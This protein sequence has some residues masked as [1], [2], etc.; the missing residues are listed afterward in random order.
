MST[1][2][3]VEAVKIGKRLAQSQVEQLRAAIE[4]LLNVAGYVNYEDEV[5]QMFEELET[6][7]NF[8]DVDNLSSVNFKLLQ[9]DYLLTWTTN[10][11]EDRETET[12]TLKSIENYVR[13]YANND[14]KGTCQFW[15]IKGTDFADIVWQY[16]TGKFLVEISKFR[17][18]EV[19][20]AFK[21]FFEKFPNGH[22]EIA[23]HGWGTSH[24]FVCRKVDKIN[25]VYEWFDKKETTVLPLH[26]AA[27]VFTLAEFNLGAK[28][29]ELSDKQ[30]VALS[31]IAQ[32]VSMPGLLD[33][34]LRRGKERTK[35]LD[36]AGIASKQRVTK[37]ED[38]VEY[39]VRCYAYTPDKEKPSTWKLPMCDKDTLQITVERLGNAAAAFS[40]GGFRG[41]PVK[42]PDAD[43]A[44]VKRRIRSEYRKLNVDLA[45]VPEGIKALI[46]ALKQLVLE[47]DMDELLKKL[48]ES[49]KAM[50]EDVRGTLTRLLDEMEK[51]DADQVGMVRQLA[52]LVAQVTEEELR[53]QLEAV[54]SAMQELLSADEEGSEEEVVAQ[55]EKI[56]KEEL[57][58]TK[59]L[60]FE[61][62]A[63][64]LKLNELSTLLETQNA[65]I[66][67]NSKAIVENGEAV[68]AIVA[69]VEAVQELV[70]HNKQ[71][72]VDIVELKETVKALNATTVELEKTDAVKVAE[73][74]ARFT[75]FWGGFRASKAAETVLDENEAKN[76]AQPEVPNIISSMVNSRL[77]GK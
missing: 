49:S 5:E 74:Q 51:A 75:P 30:R 16:V 22:P 50:H 77:G 48:R 1:N 62:I 66:A 35:I 72:T 52:E 7:K 6:E 58:E 3:I 38:G 2:K 20:Q 9:N 40:P 71:V 31:A 47:V 13:E 57:A 8:A 34:I 63:E 27:N 10:A 44:G 54:V 67:E 59:E 26:E 41:K 21:Q 28:T 73:K 70:E 46:E 14:D 56:E 19:S 69:L 64:G 4:L 45:K 60:D 76:Y 39:P 12:F 29:M 25:G 15:H 23:K 36:E 68:K 42:I 43:V 65:T 24:R 33:K 61:A 37:T 53:N 11:Y 17:N 32:E 18:D 55:E